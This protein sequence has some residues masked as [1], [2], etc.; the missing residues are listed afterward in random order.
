MRHQGKTSRIGKITLLQ[1]LVYYETTF[2]SEHYAFYFIEIHALLT[3]ISHFED[4]PVE[5]VETEKNGFKVWEDF[6]GS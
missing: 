3:E 6:F 2:I 4:C 1:L 5:K